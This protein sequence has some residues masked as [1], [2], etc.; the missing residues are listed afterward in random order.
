M[1]VAGAGS[2][3]GVVTALMASSASGFS[4][5]DRS[6]GSWP[7]AAARIARRMIFAERVFGSWRTRW[8]AD[9]ANGLPSCAATSS[10]SWAATLPSSGSPRATQ[11]AHTASPFVASGTP[12]A[13]ASATAGWVVSTD[14]TSAGARRLPATFI[15]SSERPKMNHCPS[16][17]TSAKSPCRQIPGY[18]DQYAS[19]YRCSSRHT[20]R[21]IDGHGWRQTSSPTVPRT[22]WACSSTTSTSM[23]SDGPPSEQERISSTGYGARNEPPTSVPPEKLITGTRPPNTSHASQSYESG[24]HGSPVDPRTC[25]DDRS[26]VVPPLARSVR[27]NVGETPSIVTPCRSTS[28]HSRP[29]SGTSGEP[30]YSSSVATLACVPMIESGPMI[31]PMS[32]TQQNTPPGFTS[33]E[34]ATSLATFTRNPAWVCTAPLGR[35]VVPDVYPSSSVSPVAIV[36][37]WSSGSGVTASSSHHAV[38]R[39]WLPADSVPRLS[40]TMTCSTVGQVASASSSS[41]F[42]VR[43][44]RRRTV[45]SA[46]ITALTSASCTREAIAPGAKPENSGTRTAPMRATA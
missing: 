17:S 27:I 41:G 35:P 16:S 2:P 30:S 29:R 7:R 3:A 33:N 8:T 24:S 43:L 40:I 25:T 9:G 34:Y 36:S 10:R 46:T 13:A 44:R 38:S 14:S 20:P 26:A 12:T 11:N 1:P 18:V 6:P 37:P 5:P 19:T 45:P 22:G 39:G 15:T 23:P 32:V 21:V 4:A 42:N 31:Q 28:R